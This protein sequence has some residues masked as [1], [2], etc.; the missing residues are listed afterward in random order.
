VLDAS[1]ERTWTEIERSWAT[2]AD[3][4]APERR[5]GD[6]Q[7]GAPDGRDRLPAVVV[8]GG[9]GAVL[10]VLFGV[11]RAGLAVGAAVG[12][13]WL[14]WRFLPQLERAGIADPGLSTRTRALPIAGKAGAPRSPE[15][16]LPAARPGREPRQRRA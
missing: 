6:L 3:E 10:L 1:R 7:A 11:P 9:W 5:V 2:G 14:L 13:L 15:T 8:G 16:A 12:L 4:P